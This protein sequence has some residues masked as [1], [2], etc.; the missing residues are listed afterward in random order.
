MIKK[1][2]ITYQADNQKTIITADGKNFDTSRIDGKSI[3]DWAYPFIVKNI[4]WG[5]IYDELK[6]FLGSDS[7]SVIFN[8]DDNDLAVLTEALNNTP[9]KIAIADNKIV[10]LYKSNPVSTKITVNGKIFDTSKI[11]GRTIDEWVFP[12]QFRDVKWDGIFTEIEN[13]VGTDEYS[14]QFVGT[15]E[16][17]KELMSNCPENVDL[18]FKAP[19]SNAVPKARSVAQTASANASKGAAVK[20][21]GA[22]IFSGAQSVAKSAVN[23]IKNIDFKDKLNKGVNTVQNIDVAAL[24]N[25]SG[26]MLQTAK[27]MDKDDWKSFIINNWKKLIPVAAGVILFIVIIILIFSAIFG[28]DEIEIESTDL[29]SAAECPDECDAGYVGFTTSSGS[30]GFLYFTGDD[31]TAVYRIVSEDGTDVETT[32]SESEI[33]DQQYD[34]RITG[35]DDNKDG[36]VEFTISYFDGE[37]YEEI[38]VIKGKLNEKSED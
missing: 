24:K 23:N 26:E 4:R 19:A 22:E 11:E 34:T 6:E 21:K 20:E 28:S 33:M 5:G 29:I 14:I 32:T 2:K 10:I 30:S 7:F 27:N 36:Y 25:K 16:D 17:M 35:W 1:V 37:D 38:C 8:G 15:P 3:S 18:T 9:A 12:F 31:P 13:A